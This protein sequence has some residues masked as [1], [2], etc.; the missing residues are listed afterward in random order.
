M[1]NISNEIIE[2]ILNGKKIRYEYLDKIFQKFKRSFKKNSVINIFIDVPNLLNQ[3]YNPENIKNI[4][5][6]KNKYEKYHITSNLLNIAAHYR[7]YFATRLECYTNIVF[8]Y[9]SKVDEKLK[10]IDPN[11]NKT[12]YEKRYT[13]N[14]PVFTDL[15]LLIRDNI[16]IL[17]ILLEHIPNCSF[18]DSGYMDY[19]CIF[20]FMINKEDFVNNVNIILT[21]NKLMY[22][23][24]AFDQ[25]FI[26]S[27]KADKSVFITPSNVYRSLVGNSKTIEKHPEYLTINI[28]NLPLIEGMITHKKQDTAGIKNYSYLKAL[29][30]LYKN[31]I[32]LNQKYTTTKI[33]DEIFKDKFNDIEIEIIKNNFRIYNNYLLSKE[34]EKDL[35]LKYPNFIKYTEN[36][37]D[38]RKVNETLFRKNPILMDFLF[39]GE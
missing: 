31:D 28:E 30:F 38:L 32:D 13:F 6:I 4:S 17:K 34:Y 8:M 37:D 22:Q 23:N 20:P 24:L 36:N 39:D 27:P 2:K 19:R 18:A 25:T 35:E 11:Y 7:H 15:N 12:Y 33:I 29:A 3:L 14:S 1:D 5:I 26:L 16:K 9:N 10:E 21:D